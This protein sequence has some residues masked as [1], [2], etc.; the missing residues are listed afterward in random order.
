VD[1]V[2]VTTVPMKLSRAAGCFSGLAALLLPDTNHFQ[3]DAGTTF[4]FV[5]VCTVGWSISGL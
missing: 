4:V 2:G 1:S 5:P 3:P